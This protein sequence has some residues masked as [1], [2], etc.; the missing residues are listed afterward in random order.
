MAAKTQPARGMRDF[1]PADLRK[2]GYVIGVIKDV[3]ERYGF[4]PLETPAVENIETLLGK[5]GEEGNQ[6]IFKI[7][8]RG[9]H[10][11]TGEADL[12]LRYDL[13]VPLAR[14]V[15][16]YGDKLPRFFKRYQIQ[17]VWRADR[18]A[19]GRFREFY[20]C[21]VDCIGTRSAVVEAE[22]CAAASDVLRTLGFDNFTIRLN[23][24]QV[25]AGVLEAAGI[26]ADRH[27][28]ALV[29]IDKLDKVGR[30][31]VARE[32]NA[33]GIDA[34]GGEKLLDFFEKLPEL[35]RAAEF[36]AGGGGVEGVSTAVAY[37]HAVLGR[38]VEFVGGHDAGALGIE[39]LRAIVEYA[40]AYGVADKIKIDP[41]LARGLSYYTGAIMEIAVPDLAGSL[42][43][44]GRYDNL[45]GMFS[46]KD[47]PA[48]GF[49]LGLERIIVV[50]TERGMFPENLGRASADVLVTV[51]SEESVKDSLA[52]AAELRKS[53]PSLRVD[54]YPDPDKLGKQLKYASALGVPFVVIIGDEERARGEIALKDM[55]TGEQRTLKR[56]QAG[57]ELSE[58][59]NGAAK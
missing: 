4:E 15:A 37:N 48:C 12:A 54:V 31:G 7:L 24:R 42:G 18:P 59:L 3:Y 30:E 9:E 16:E 23:H 43:G 36:V 40:E 38:L 10:E 22:I 6:L 44:G 32:F 14:V 46:G 19:R 26:A 2:R 1:L 56:E 27:G 47:I 20:Q 33:R 51:W 50:M 25:L 57:A 28:E 39:N 8:K 5:Y 11:K 13:T 53:A 35:E 21:D 29:A 49:S 52:F 17:P 45:V 58:A 55:K 41:S 34:A